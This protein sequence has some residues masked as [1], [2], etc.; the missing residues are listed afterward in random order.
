MQNANIDLIFILGIIWAQVRYMHLWFNQAGMPGRIT[1]L[2]SAAGNDHLGEFL[3]FHLTHKKMK[4]GTQNLKRNSS[5]CTVSVQQLYS[6]S[7]K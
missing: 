6:N 1:R 4:S 7:N 2:L 3:L 5:C